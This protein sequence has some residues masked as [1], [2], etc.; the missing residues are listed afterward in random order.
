MLCWLQLEAAAIARAATTSTTSA[1]AAAAPHAK[2]SQSTEA[3][4]SKE[5][6]VTREAFMACLE[7]VLFS[8]TADKHSSQRA[9]QLGGVSLIAAE[10]RRRANEQCTDSTQSVRTISYET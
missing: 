4:A 8:L 5:A 1:T 10:L 3:L 6:F 2:V 7:P 9:K